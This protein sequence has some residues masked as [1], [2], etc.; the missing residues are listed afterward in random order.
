MRLE[1]QIIRLLPYPDRDILQICVSVIIFISV[2]RSCSHRRSVMFPAKP[3]KINKAH[4]SVFFKLQHPVKPRFFII[5]P[6]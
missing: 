1:C 5:F 4:G 6:L 2:S 3:S